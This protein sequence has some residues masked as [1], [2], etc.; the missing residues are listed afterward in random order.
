MLKSTSGSV[1]AGG[2]LTPCLNI[3]IHVHVSIT[4]VYTCACML[5]SLS[6]SHIVRVPHHSETILRALLRLVAD[7]CP[8]YDII[9]EQNGTVAMYFYLYILAVFGFESGEVCLP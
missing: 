1:C 3:I 7:L 4:V 6:C 2:V 5:T 9:P 8:Q